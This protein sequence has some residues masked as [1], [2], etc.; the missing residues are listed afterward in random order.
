MPDNVCNIAAYLPLMA[1]R[2]PDQPAVVGTS[3][4]DRN[5]R[6]C[7][8]KLSFRELEARSNRYANGLSSAGI[9]RGTRVLV[10]VRPGLGFIGL[11][12]ALFKIGAVPILI[13]PG[14]GIKRLLECVRHVKPQAFV[15]IPLAHAVRVLR[16]SAFGAVK[17]VVT[18]GRRW[19]WGGPTLGGL[20]ERASSEFEMVPT[21]ADETAAILFTSGSTGPAKGVVYEHGMFDA[22]VRAIQTCY[23]IEPGEVDLPAFPLFALFSTAMGMTCVIP[24]MDPSRPATVEP[25][26][27]VEAI[28]DHAV[29]NTFGS[30]AIW[31]RV[32]QYCV[33]RGIT[34]PTLRRVLIAGAP[35]SYQL[36]EQMHQVLNPSADV[37]T[38]YGATESL[39]VS[40]ISGREVLDKCRESSRQ[41]AGTC[42][43]RPLP[44]ITLRIIRISDEP[45]DTWSDD[46]VLCHS[47]N[48]GLG[49][50]VAHGF[51]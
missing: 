46:L 37:H 51:S 12:F 50:G 11:I 26:K 40:S 48:E 23:G 18:V 17:H 22:Q 20:A 21:R 49:V 39:P 10:M 13:D 19:F 31:N 4:R 29:T 5:G 6:A 30:P 44:G 36:I 16:P 3:G 15:G 41:G 32:A 42:V 14:M 25:A 45:I 8:T 35:V 28:Q 34:L 43:G 7:Y 47:S 27:I 1:Q 2:V 38:P 33:Q 24:D 9:G